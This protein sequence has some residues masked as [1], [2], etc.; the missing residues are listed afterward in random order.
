MNFIKKIIRG[1][2][3]QKVYRII[4]KLVGF[5]PKQRNLV[6][7]ESFHGKQ[8]SD[9]PRAIY[10]YM[11][12]HYSDA[13]LWWSVDR[14]HTDLFK[15]M[16]L[17]YVKRFTLKWF[18]LMPRAKYWVNNVRLPNWLPKPKKT[19]Y[20]QTWH[21]TP[22]KRLGVD[23]EEVRMPGTST[24]KYKKNF[25]NESLKW[26]YLVSPNRYSTEIFRRAFGFNGEVIESGYPRNDY[27]INH[28]QKDVEQIK[29][30][31]NIP[32]NQKVILYAPTWRDDEY[33]SVGNY[34]F[35]I[36]LDLDKL[37]QEFEDDYVVLLRMHYLISENLDL[38]DYNGFAYDVS[39]YVDIRDLYIIS[40]MLITD[41][42][43]VFF[44]YANLK[45]PII[46]YVYDLHKYKEDLR[47]FYFD[48]E[49]KAPGPLTFSTSDVINQIKHL[50]ANGI[51]EGYYNE[52]Y[53]R[54]CYLEDGYA[55]KRVVETFYN[56]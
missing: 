43:S 40:D 7:F 24:E 13:E 31:L 11:K 9:S 49:D 18:W 26:D 4:F 17:P 56:N 1:K 5:L 51:P 22:L 36:K 53:E 3:A 27:L 2:K 8:Y 15:E 50:E 28:S 42:S 46:F 52:F 10:E 37:K 45:R 14:R 19:V 32:L 47:G 33:Y 21:G 34:K 44:D 29:E 6:I 54:F 48:I 12:D 35:D 39:D 38:S 41:Y 16:E 25:L 20:I 55:S 30:E 23:I